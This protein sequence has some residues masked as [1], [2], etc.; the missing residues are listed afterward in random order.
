[1]FDH[2]VR[3]SA[4]SER[5][6]GP[7]VPAL[8]VL[9]P[10]EQRILGSLLEKQITVPGSYPLSLN[11]LRTACNQSSSREPVMELEEG[12]V[13]QSARE[14]KNR[15]LLRIVWSDSGRRTLKYHQTLTELLDLDDAARALITVLLLRGPQP[16]GAL[17]TRTERLHGFADRAEV[18]ATLNV[19]ARTEPPL[20]AE[21]PRQGGQH[22]TRWVHLLGPSEQ[23]LEG[24]DGPGDAGEREVPL[25][26][27]AEARDERVRASYSALAAAYSDRFRDE[28]GESSFEAWFLGR[29]LDLAGPH[30]IVDVGCGPGHVSA[31]LAAKGADVTGIDLSPGMVEQARKNHPDGSFAVGDLRTLMRPT[32]DSGWGAVL[33]W[34][35]LIHLAPSELPEALA[36]LARPICTET[37]WLAVALHSGHEVLHA[38]T[39]LDTEVDLDVVQ[40]QPDDVVAAVEAAGLVDVEWYHRGAIR[41]QHEIQDRLYLLARKP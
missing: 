18:E 41:A 5:S 15:E 1:M 25:R 13:E 40:Y 20:V 6:T 33:A 11:A 24:R 27:G 34:Y 23:P 9:D 36:A 22:D 38:E 32:N 8:P 3:V 31:R 29:V 7:A 14:L 26:D 12:E 2:A 35:S 4:M 37:G 30:P 21:L 16:A 10:I 17:K 28:F 39:W 19:L